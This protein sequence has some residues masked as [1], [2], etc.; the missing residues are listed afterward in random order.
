[1][2]QRQTVETS[3]LDEGNLGVFFVLALFCSLP[4]ENWVLPH[5]Q[6]YFF[7][8]VMSRAILSTEFHL[9]HLK[10]LV[11]ISICKKV[12]FIYVFCKVMKSTWSLNNYL[13]W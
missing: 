13:P 12:I 5:L 11:S 2:F 1:M 8:L 9:D 10:I 3:L 6:S 4:P 7:E